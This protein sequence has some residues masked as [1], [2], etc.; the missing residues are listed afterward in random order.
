MIT[1]DPTSILRPIMLM[2][3][4]DKFLKLLDQSINLV[5]KGLGCQILLT[6]SIQLQQ[7]DPS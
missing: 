7:K 6:S 5:L 4:R 3:Y 1:T 2:S